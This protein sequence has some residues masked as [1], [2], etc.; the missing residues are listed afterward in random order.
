MPFQ[1]KDVMQPANTIL[2]DRGCARWPAP[3]LLAWLNEG[4]R[5]IVTVKP[6]ASTDPVVLT[7]VAGVSQTLPDN[8]TALVEPTRN[9]ASN[10]PIF[11]LQNRDVLDQVVPGW[12]D[13]A[14][15]NRANDIEYMIHDLK[16][17][18]RFWICPGALAG[19]Q[20]EVIA[21]VMPSDVPEGASHT[22]ISTYTGIVPLPDV[23]RN[24]LVNY[25]LYRA[26]SK[27]SGIAGAAQRA[28]AHKVLFDNGLAAIGGAEAAVSAG[29][30]TSAGG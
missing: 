24:M 29:T 15:I 2:V 19:A 9:V 30:N 12:M 6:N 1:A 10:K 28:E 26:F 7:L 3:E 11:L 16:N 4:I 17:P 21:G 18:R 13:A 20:I 22:I 27:D 25:V 5:E 23:Y 8:V 14:V